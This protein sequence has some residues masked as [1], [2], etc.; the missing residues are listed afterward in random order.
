[1]TQLDSIFT[2]DVTTVISDSVA[3]EETIPQTP[4][5]V[6]RLLPKDTAPVELPQYYRE[7]NFVGD[8]LYYQEVESGNYG[9]PGT[10]LAY[11]AVH[12]NLISSIL[13]GCLLFFC[14]VFSHFWD[15]IAQQAK[16]IFY[17]RK[18][19]FKST[20]NELQ[21]MLGLLTTSCIV[22]SILYY[23]YVMA[24]VSETHI[25]SSDYLLLAVFF[26]VIV[27]YHALHFLLYH[28][29]N[30]TFFDKRTNRK[31]LTSNLFLSGMV[32]ILL[33][34]GIFLLA[35]Y[36]FTALSMVIYAG[37]VLFLVKILSFYKS[38]NIF[39]KRNVFFLQI[40]LYFCALEIIPLVML[41]G[42][43]SAIVD[44]LKVN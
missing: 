7:G 33:L 11:M 20:S 1:M 19:Q 43:L 44:I 21:L 24:F 32:G 26:G 28:I 12:D 10:P 17:S 31:F 34:P 15:F 16:A 6:L 18:E 38:Y 2:S 36:G 25:L 37:F 27:A 3:I 40:I 23:L 14:F 41:I 4:I 8:T 5:Q 22:C 42:G 35:H 13:F 29:V 9:V 30:I 39:F